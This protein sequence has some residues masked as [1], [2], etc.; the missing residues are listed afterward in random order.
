MSIL[1]RWLRWR[2]AD[3]GTTSVVGSLMTV[4]IVF[5]V[6][7]SVGLAGLTLGEEVTTS[8]SDPAPIP[9]IDVEPTLDGADNHGV[10]YLRL[11]H[12]VGDRVDGQSILIRDSDGNT[13]TWSDIYE[14]DR[15]MRG[16]ESIH[17]DGYGPSDGHLNC[18]AEGE[19]YILVWQASNG[20]SF[21]IDRITLDQSPPAS[22][23]DECRDGWPPG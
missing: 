12:E 4:V 3:R 10:A 19:T 14:G 16:G 18:L 1:G 6:A 13:V 2:G 11:V 15:Y 17:L 5:V 22:S 21:V 20:D 7:G 23:L 9:H 8:V